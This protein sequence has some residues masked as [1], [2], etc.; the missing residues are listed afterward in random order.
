MLN[1][2]TKTKPW[3]V[4]SLLA[5]TSI[6]AQQDNTKCRPQKSFDQGHEMS[7]SQL[8]SGYN[9]PARVEVRGSWD[10]YATG[11]FIYWQAQQEN[12]EIGLLS[13]NDPEGK[14]SYGADLPFVSTGS[15]AYLNNM[16][17]TSPN[18]TYRPGFK[19]GLG[20]NLDWDNWD[21]FAEYTWFHG[22]TGSGV[23]PQTG[24]TATGTSLPNG[25]YLY[26]NLDAAGSYG[27]NAGT[28]VPY[29]YNNADQSWTLK[30]DFLDVSMA[31]S[32]Y[33]GTKLTVRPF[34][35]ARGAWIR[36]SINTTY[37]G[38]TNYTNANG[39]YNS[40]DNAYSSSWGVGPRAGFES[41]WLL[42]YGT[43]FLGNA[44]ADILYTRFVVHQDNKV[45]LHSSSGSATPVKTNAAV[46][47]TI[48]L[49]RAHADLE[50][51]FGWGSYFDNNNWHVDLSAMYGFQIFWDQNMFRN[52]VSFNQQAKS[53]APNGNLYVHG[54]TMNARLDF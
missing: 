19:F 54:L 49:L 48:D 3:V 28:S 10:V 14:T 42:G 8:M 51:G 40:H 23:K 15:N 45:V 35:G 46:S 31:R 30:M 16:T 47:Q 34:F 25:T 1:L 41:N 22:S 38:S 17:V 37:N 39:Y 26:S 27:V 24:D 44:S 20:V 4:A 9:A 32:Y 6:F 29:F 53:F 21:G 52:F 33:S 2:L 7:Q 43:R 18:F 13:H 36:Q 12:M 50:M 11:S 5:S